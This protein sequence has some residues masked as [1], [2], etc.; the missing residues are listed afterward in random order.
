MLL[1]DANISWKLL[2]ALHL[3]IPVATNECARFVMGISA[4]PTARMFAD[5]D[6]P[7]ASASFVGHVQ[8]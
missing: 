7:G 4:S 2:P 8:S 1:D 3:Q 5:G 6:V